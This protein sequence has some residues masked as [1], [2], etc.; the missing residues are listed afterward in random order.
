MATIK[1][2]WYSDHPSQHILSTIQK[3]NTHKR[4][5]NSYQWN[6]GPYP[7]N[8]PTYNCCLL[9]YPHRIAKTPQVTFNSPIKHVYIQLKKLL[10]TI[11]TTKNRKIKPNHNPF[12]QFFVTVLWSINN[13]L[14]TTI[15]NTWYLALAQT[16]KQK[17]KVREH[18]CQIKLYPCLAALLQGSDIH[19]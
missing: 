18:T 12:S 14:E 8:A 10:A 16:R 17:K 15:M 3:E 5:F 13:E 9:N 19:A 6:L 11:Y 7:V 2:N 1:R 4:N